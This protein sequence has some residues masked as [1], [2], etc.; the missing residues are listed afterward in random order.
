MCD[1]DDD[2]GGGCGGL[3]LSS[4]LELAAEKQHVRLCVSEKVNGVVKK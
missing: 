2:G 1:D 3:G 4:S